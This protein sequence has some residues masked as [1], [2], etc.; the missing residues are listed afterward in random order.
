MTTTTEPFAPEHARYPT[1]VVAT[2]QVVD[3]LRVTHDPDRIE[4]YCEA[5]R[6]GARFPP[7]SVLPIAGR[8]VIADG[9]RRFQAFL[10]LGAHDIVVELWPWHAVARD[11]WQQHRAFMGGTVDAVRG[12]L[13]GG[14]ARQRGR[15]FFRELLDHWR[16]IARSLVATVRE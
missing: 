11:L 9:H 13:S 3:L 5:M 4:E 14:Q 8:F 6:R 16:R 2:R 10:T 7:I 15:R 1:R 12:L